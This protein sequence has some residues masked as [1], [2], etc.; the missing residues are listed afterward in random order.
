MNS[1]IEIKKRARS[2]NIS[3]LKPL[4]VA[5][6][7]NHATQFYKDALR[8]NLMLDGFNPEI[9]EA[10]YNQIDL[11]ILEPGSKL[12][13][14]EPSFIIIF[15]S[16]LALRKEFLSRSEEQER[17]QFYKAK[18]KQLIN[19]VSIIKQNLPQSKILVYNYET[20]LDNVFGSFYPKVSE[21][22]KYQLTE[23]NYCLFR[24]TIQERSLSLID[25]N[26]ILLGLAS[27]RDWSLY[28]NADVHYSL[29]A[30]VVLSRHASQLMVSAIGKIKKCLILDLDNTIWGGIIGDDGLNGIQIGPSGIGKSFQGLQTW[31]KQLRSRG[32]ILAVCSKNEESIAKTPFQEHPD[33]VLRLPDISVFVANWD[34]KADNIRH[35]K[36]ILNIGYD[37]I[38]FLDDNLMERNIVKENL[39][40]VTV[41]ELP[42]DPALYLPFLERLNLFE[43]SSFSKG[44]KDRTKQYQQEAERKK[45][46]ASYTNMDDYLK[47]LNM[48][49]VVSSFEEFDVPRIAQLTQRSNQFNLR[50]IRYSESDISRIMQSSDYMTYSVKLDDKF[51]SYGLIS[52]VILKKGEEESYCI[53]TW[54]MSCRVLKR[55]VEYLIMNQI[56]S[57]LEKLDIQFLYGEYIKTPK[58]NLV[59]SLL[60]ELGLKKMENLDKYG[61]EISSIPYFSHFIE[62]I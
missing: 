30:C 10:D 48:N 15:E 32:I 47:S 17:K 11:T 59:V 52:V 21:S 50:T 46:I 36:E 45:T 42:S 16:V 31:A 60:S 57:D 7:G 61:N 22:F 56:K 28:V 38:V 41:P 37:S 34:N 25:V 6:L 62:V 18:E 35:I 51:G 33:M 4:K 49:A 53:D 20:T 44:D 8:Y 54:L 13:E 26:S 14:I 58:N 39:P 3:N 29:D 23:L 19:R 27:Y 55:G 5:I 9:F 43:T 1:L 2:I 24:M 12:Y 40:E